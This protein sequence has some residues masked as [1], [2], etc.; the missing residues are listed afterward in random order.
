MHFWN[1]INTIFAN[2]KSYIKIC[3]SLDRGI[4]TLCMKYNQDGLSYC[5]KGEYF[6]KLDTISFK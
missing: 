4:S 1:K 2:T 5:F 6:L 3:H